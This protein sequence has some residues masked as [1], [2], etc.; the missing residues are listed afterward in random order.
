M[1]TSLRHKDTISSKVGPIHV[2]A[3]MPREGT[4]S[5]FVE[6][7][8]TGVEWMK[9]GKDNLWTDRM[10]SLADNCAWLG[11]VIETA[12]LYLAGAGISI[13]TKAGE[14]HEVAMKMYREWT[15]AVGDEQ[16]RYRTGRDI[17]KL[18]ARV[19][20]YRYDTNGTIAAIDHLSASSVRL[21]KYIKPKWDIQYIYHSPDWS[22]INS[23]QN[24]ERFTPT[25]YPVFD[26]KTKG[27]AKKTGQLEYLC[28][29]KD[30]KAYGEPWWL[31]CIRDAETWVKL[32]D[33]TRNQVETG[34]SAM[35][36][37]DVVGNLT[38]KEQVALQKNI[39]KTYSGSRGN[40]IM[41]VTR[42]QGEDKLTVTPVPRTGNAEEVIKL[43]D[44]AKLEGVQAALIPP[45]L[46][47]IDVKTGMD[48][49]GL[50]IEQEVERFMNTVIRPKQRYFIAD[51]LRKALELSG[52][53]DIGKVEVLEL[54]AFGSV[55]DSA[56]QSA[57][58]MASHRQYCWRRWP[59]APALTQRHRHLALARW[60]SRW[61]SRLCWITR[62]T[63]S[64]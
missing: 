61:P 7:N 21:G 10:Q 26:Q 25:P 33:F 14:P 41:V 18:N 64:W 63:W 40:A 36:I 16:W 57:A 42:K 27:A 43:R 11:T 54:K 37:L 23:A 38:A 58:Y 3:M 2:F 19:W 5:P 28:G 50:A 52:I 59:C 55:L 39:E 46:C 8:A 20:H 62:M 15:S 12:G 30:D 56:T 22:K 29:Y 53:K 51:P 9:L 6:E 31:G 17:A 44:A 13:T 1:D 49:K 32:A 48:G 24:K 4:I 35:V 47:G 45:I 34:F 60:C